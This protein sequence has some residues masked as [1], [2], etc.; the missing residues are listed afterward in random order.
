[1]PTVFG[2]AIL[3]GTAGWA[4]PRRLLPAGAVIAGAVCSALPDLDAIGL[5]IGIPYHH[6]LGHRGFSHSPA[7]ALL[8]AGVLTLASSR[9]PGYRGSRP[10]LF[11]FL[12]LSTAS[13]G[14]LDAM[15]TGG[16]G[17]AFLSPFSNERFFLPWR[18][19]VVSPLDPTRMLSSW[20]VRVLVSEALW[21]GMPAL[22]IV[23]TRLAIA[24]RLRRSLRRT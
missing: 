2:H 4:L 19:I 6:W 9:L 10:A 23:V 17:V 11:A 14:L 8:L 18:P 20:G 15:T 22:L 21:I 1:M 5:R 12:A 3:G 24:R 16:L 13:H 7:F